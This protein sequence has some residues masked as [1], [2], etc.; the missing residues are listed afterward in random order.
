MPKFF[1][2]NND[3]VKN[4]LYQALKDNL[5]DGIS[6]SDDSRIACLLK[7]VS[8]ELDALH[9]YLNKC[10]NNL[11]IQKTYLFLDRVE[12]IYGLSYNKNLNYI[13]RLNRL[14]IFVSSYKQIITYNFLYEKL[15][16]LAPNLFGNIV[17]FRYEDGLSHIFGTD[18]S[19]K[20]DDVT[21]IFP[22]DEYLKTEGGYDIVGGNSY[23]YYKGSS[24]KWF[25][26]TL[27]IGI[28]INEDKDS[29]TVKDRKKIEI[30]LISE[31]LLKFLPAH[32]DFV[33][34]VDTNFT[35]ADDELTQ[36]SKL[37]SFSALS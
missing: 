19:R 13:D 18:Y 31:Y 7:T 20:I 32:I 25:S 10:A 22:T 8:I 17:L 21:I 24:D 23:I 33:F 30:D 26:T 28:L 34:F 9:S 2:N 4:A 3:P 35:A 36:G 16:L 37:D 1:R 14:K 15:K 6:E 12:K 5:G 29:I 11:I 27:T